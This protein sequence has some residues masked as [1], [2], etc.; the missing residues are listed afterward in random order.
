MRENAPDA[1]KN[2]PG[3]EGPG[4][5][6]TGPA[7]PAAQ[8]QTK[9]LCKSPAPRPAERATALRGEGIG[10]PPVP[11]S[12]RRRQTQGDIFGKDPEIPYVKF[13]AAA[14]DLVCSLME[15]QDRMNEE[16]FYRIND[17]GYR[18]EDLEE[19]RQ[20]NGGGG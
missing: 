8:E 9:A 2:L 16:I 6:G 12:V 15:R 14:R 20:G 3:P 17:L 19:D 1:E 13:E 10:R 18:L 5:P 4:E 11:K 7:S